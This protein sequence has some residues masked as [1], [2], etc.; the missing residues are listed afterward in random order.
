MFQHATMA[1]DP[2]QA[3]M[4]QLQQALAVKDE[5]LKQLQ[6]I[7]ENQQ[8]VI[9]REKADRKRARYEQYPLCP[10]EEAVINS[11]IQGVGTQDW[12]Y[13]ASINRKWHGMYLAFRKKSMRRKMFQRQ[14]SWYSA[15]GS[16]S[17]VQ[18]AT[19][20]GLTKGKVREHGEK[21]MTYTLKNT[22]DALGVLRY[23]TSKGMM[24]WTEPLVNALAAHAIQKIADPVGS[25]ASLLDEG[26]PY[27]DT[28]IQMLGEH[29]L[30]HSA[31]PATLRPLLQAGVPWTTEVALMPLRNHSAA[32]GGSRPDDLCLL[33]GVR[34]RSRARAQRVRP[35]SDRRAAQPAGA[36]AAL[37]SRSARAAVRRLRDRDPLG[38]AAVGVRQWCADRG[39]GLDQ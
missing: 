33:D 30:K 39:G 13:V 37:G 25:L 9:A 14:T 28:L 7:V 27:T 32:L 23:L 4:S 5:Q 16:V 31:D 3:T 18:F 26:M 2:M 36:H 34:P 29:S 20:H 1:H 11:V 12:V 19:E 24:P 17:R 35:G 22:P 38:G 8:A 6:Q 21:L 15:M 10:W